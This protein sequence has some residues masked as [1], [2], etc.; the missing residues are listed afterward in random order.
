VEVDGGGDEILRPGE[1]CRP[2]RLWI[3][4]RTRSQEHAVAQGATDGADDVERIGHGH[5]DLDDGDAALGEGAAD[6]DELLAVGGAHDGDDATVEDTAEVGFLAHA[7]Y[8]AA[9]AARRPARGWRCTMNSST[10]GTPIGGLSRGQTQALAVGA[11]GPEV[12]LGP[13]RLGPRA[14]RA[15]SRPDERSGRVGAKRHPGL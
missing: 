4:D 13:D 15:R 14:G 9:R 11:D 12:L 3:E 5:G 1:E 8:C 7:G 2:S 10:L 6:L